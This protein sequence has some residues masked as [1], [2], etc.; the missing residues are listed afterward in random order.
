MASIVAGKRRGCPGHGGSQS[1]LLKWAGVGSWLVIGVL[2]GGCAARSN[3]LT[4]ASAP[5][6]TAS[7]PTG[8]TPTS[9]PQPSH[10][11]SKPMHTAAKKHH[12][13]ARPV[14]DVCPSS[15]RVLVGV[16]HTDRLRVIGSCRHVTGT[17]ISTTPEEDGD[18]HFDV[19]LDSP[20]RSMLMAT[21]TPKSTVPWW[22]S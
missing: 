20:Y 14:L 9:T 11:R 3:S 22:S 16:Y 2:T 15:S 4:T 6:P 8:P 7:Q 17:V 5:A 13:K 12:A 19:H 1:R 10:S 18:L 21:T